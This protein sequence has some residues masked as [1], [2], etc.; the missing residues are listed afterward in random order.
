MAKQIKLTP[1]KDYATE[2]NAIKAVEK[3]FPKFENVADRLNYL[4]L[5][6]PAG[7]FYP[8]FVGERAIQAGAHFSFCVVN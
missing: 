7:R 2:A 4:I 8:V 1:M 3:V 5:Q 6:T